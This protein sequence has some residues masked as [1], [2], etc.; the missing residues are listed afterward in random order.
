MKRTKPSIK[1]T[2]IIPST[3]HMR[4]FLI[5]KRNADRS[6]YMRLTNGKI[7]IGAVIVKGNYVISEGHNKRKTH[8]FQ[9]VHNTKALYKA[10]TPNIHAE[11]DC[12]IQSR[13][14]DLSGCEVYVYRDLV[15]G[16]LGDCRPCAACM[17]AL[18]DAGVRHVYYT[19]TSGYHYERLY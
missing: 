18:V 3:R 14:N 9:H 17:N 19:S 16:G 5:A 13:F 10:P 15:I 8:T 2:L 7:A 1:S 12:L 6:T 4:Y 11:I